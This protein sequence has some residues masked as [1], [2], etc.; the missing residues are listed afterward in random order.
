MS[1]PVEGESVHLP[2]P[3]LLLMRGP[4]LPTHL[5]LSLSF[6]LFFHTHPFL[7]LSFTSPELRG[8]CAN[9]PLATASRG[10]SSDSLWPRP[11]GRKERL[12]AQDVAVGPTSLLSVKC[13][14]SACL[15]PRPWCPQGSTASSEKEW[16]SSSLLSAWPP[17]WPS[18]FSSQS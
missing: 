8:G 1:G 10:G 9:L 7:F 3:E 12:P 17:L 18:G 16:G 14:H 13:I 11:S 4:S 5:R 15:G 2:E 6:T